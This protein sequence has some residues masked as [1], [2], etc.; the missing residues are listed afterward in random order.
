M[1]LL[2]CRPCWLAFLATVSLGCW[3]FSLLSVA[4]GA[5]AVCQREQ[6][7]CSKISM[8]VAP[9]GTC[10]TQQG[11]NNHMEIQKQLPS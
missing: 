11:C 4:T 7:C 10:R 6:W 3:F 5:A 9:S 1:L 2:G 8:V